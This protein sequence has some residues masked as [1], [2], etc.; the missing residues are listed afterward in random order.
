VQSSD[1]VEDQDE[2]EIDVRAHARSSGPEA[3]P[4][5]SATLTQGVRPRL[6]GGSADLLR[7]E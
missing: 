5:R 7:H 3:A 2:D 6:H 1:R 4:P